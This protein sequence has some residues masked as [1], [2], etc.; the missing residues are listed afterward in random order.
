M[1]RIL[2]FLFILFIAQSPQTF[3]QN[4]NRCGMVQYMERVKAQDP[5]LADRIKQA[6]NNISQASVQ[7]ANQRTTSTIITIP[8]VFH[9]LYRSGLQNISQA[10]IVDQINVLN[11]DYARVNAD[12]FNTPSPF[13]SVAATSNIRFCLAQRDPN[14]A[15]TTGV[16]RKSVTATGF[17]PISNDN[18]KYTS[19]GGDDAW[20]AS[21]YLN[22]WICN[23]NGSSN[24]ILGISQFPGGAAATDGCCVLYSTVGGPQYPGTYTDFDKGRTLTHEVGHWLALRHIWG[25]DM[26]ACTGS[27]YVSD[28]PNQAGENYGCPTFPLSDACN[29]SSSGV[30]FMNYMDYVNDICMNM[31][32]AGQVARMA[33]A[34]NLYR[35]AITNSNGCLAPVGTQDLATQ[36]NFSVYPNPA[37]ESIRITAKLTKPGDGTIQLFNA[38]GEV[39]YQ[40]AFKSEATID[41]AV[42]I[43]GFAQGIYS[44][45]LKTDE[46]AVYKKVVITAR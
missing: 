29:T 32:T 7:A 46:G 28:T 45:S 26:G 18:A 3:S 33:N 34:I 41:N 25:D 19:L 14:G 40:V 1:K 35:S 31:F 2:T 4:A 22:V 16:I 39:V 30:M 9:V 27:D 43:S 44:V 36:L 15:F 37:S 8:V 42:N 6:E 21:S 5:G 24:Q 23:F 10:R 38:I 17:D 13:K 12:T 20:P 11:A